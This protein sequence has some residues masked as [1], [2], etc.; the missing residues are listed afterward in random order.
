MTKRQIIGVYSNTN[1]CTRTFVLPL[2]KQRQWHMVPALKPCKIMTEKLLNRQT[3]DKGAQETSRM[4]PAFGLWT[5]IIGLHLWLCWFGSVVICCFCKNL[6]HRLEQKQ[7]QQQQQQQQKRLNTHTHTHTHWELCSVGI[8]IIVFCPL[9]VVSGATVCNVCNYL[10]GFSGFQA[11]K[12]TERE[13]QIFY[14][15]S[16]F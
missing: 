1:S 15:G 2:N 13:I 12:S 10:R 11:S 5:F 16:F 6:L 14:N 3:N 7:Q 4:R 8:W 9:T